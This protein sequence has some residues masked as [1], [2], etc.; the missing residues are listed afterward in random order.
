MGG[1]GSNGASNKRAVLLT[2][3]LAV[4]LVPLCWLLMGDAGG[5][6]RQVAVGAAGP[7]PLGRSLESQVELE[8][9]QTERAIHVPLPLDNTAAGG[10]EALFAEPLDTTEAGPGAVVRLVFQDHKGNGLKDVR[11]GLVRRGGMEGPLPWGASD[12]IGV[13]VWSGLEPGDYRW[14]L[15]AGMTAEMLPV[16]RKGLS[17]SFSVFLADGQ[18][19]SGPFALVAGEQARF[20]IRCDLGATVTGRL[21]IRGVQLGAMVSVLDLDRGD[22]KSDRKRRRF[23]AHVYAHGAFTIW[24]LP[25]KP[26]TLQAVWHDPN[27]NWY[28]YS[29][30]VHPQADSTVDLGTLKVST[31]NVVRV[32]AVMQDRREGRTQVID[33]CW[34]DGGPAYAL[35]SLSGCLSVSIHIPFG[36]SVDLCGIALD[37]GSLKVGTE[38]TSQAWPSTFAGERV[39]FQVPKLLEIDPTAGAFL[40]EIPF[41]IVGVSSVQAEPPPR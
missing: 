29:A 12:E 1:V 26:F 16:P 6:T 41:A 19:A 40:H 18:R 15:D 13:L 25:L 33:F 35:L 14:I 28:F 17:K 32:A 38:R 24:N 27:W 34:P 11:A 10:N 31:R 5:G 30:E 4:L 20:V 9:G 3:A 7:Q 8:P 37:Q 39:D 22:S 23:R 21:P 36:R 2:A